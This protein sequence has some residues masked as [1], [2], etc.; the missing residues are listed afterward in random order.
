M[1]RGIKYSFSLKVCG[2]G[3]TKC[4]V[5]KDLDN[6]GVNDFEAGWIS[7]FTGSSLGDCDRFEMGT[8]V[9]WTI[10]MTVMHSG[11]MLCYVSFGR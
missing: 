7:S 2:N 8:G 5:A 9:D 3:T 11:K 1:A 6:P 10:A 4:C